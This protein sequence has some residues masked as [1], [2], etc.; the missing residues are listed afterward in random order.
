M[1]EREKQDE[2]NVFRNMYQTTEPRKYM[3]MLYPCFDIRFSESWG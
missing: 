2:G 3:L 1:L